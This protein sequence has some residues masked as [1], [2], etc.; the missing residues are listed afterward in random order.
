MFE[1]VSERLQRQIHLAGPGISLTKLV[2][3]IYLFTGLT[4]GPAISISGILTAEGSSS[5]VKSSGTRLVGLLR[6]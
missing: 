6:L 3:H 5:F 2:P 1:N 4:C